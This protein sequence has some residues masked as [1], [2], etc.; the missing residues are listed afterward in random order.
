MGK[1]CL[2]E[3]LKFDC[4]VVYTFKPYKIPVEFWDSTGGPFWYSP[5]SHLVE[6]YE[7]DG[8][9]GTMICTDK[10]AR[11]ILPHIMTGEKKTVEEW[12]NKVY[13]QN[14]N[15]GFNGESS[16]EVGRFEF[17]LY[18]ILAKKA[19]MPLHRFLGATKDYVNVYGSG[20]GTHLTDEQML[21]EAAEFVEAGFKTV[22]MK[23]ATDFG[24]DL[25]NDLRRIA[26]VRKEIGD[27][28]G[29]AIDANQYFTSEEALDFIKRAE[30]YQIEWYEEPVH[31]CDFNGLEKLCEQS[32]VPIAM[33]ESMRNHYMFEQYLRCGVKHFQPCPS[34]C[35]GISEWMK[36][37]D[38]AQEHQITLTSGGL[39]YMAQVLISTADENAREEY[40]API[41]R[42]QR[43][44]LS[45]KW[46]EKDG[47][48]IMP[49]VPGV[50]FKV[51]LPLMQKMGQILKKDYY[52]PEI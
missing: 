41:E 39:P 21:K 8:V 25:D 9:V 7:A 36:I 11:V 43:E 4:A 33:G 1:D 50:P 5:L 23:I 46:E 22:K 44:F 40:L 10:M 13:W 42:W 49:D 18:D 17:L 38:L 47:K 6:L 37:R 16:Y 31:C 32:P 12:M 51:D 19:N 30:E 28:I 26:L 34:N 45:V 27:H 24:A 48:F 14:R 35:G 29:L 20:M 52:Y 3:Q 2:K 15:N